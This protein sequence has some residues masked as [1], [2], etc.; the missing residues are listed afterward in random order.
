MAKISV[1]GPLAEISASCEGFG[2]V[3]TKQLADRLIDLVSA[4]LLSFS[5]LAVEIDA[6]NQAFLAELNATKFYAITPAMA[7]LVE[8]PQERFSDDVLR[9]FPEAASDIDEAGRCY[10]FGRHTAC[11]FHLMRVL[12]VP[13]QH[14]AKTLLPNDRKPNWAPII[15]KID[16]ELKLPYKQRSIIGPESFW[17]DVSARM[18]AVKIAWRNRVMHVDSIVTAE[19]AS[20]IFDATCGLMNFLS[21]HAEHFLHVDQPPS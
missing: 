10:A 2:G 16:T 7:K 5:K 20:S 15:E 11:V 17:A 14:L 1:T 8:R 19:R 18:H 3:V 6:L 9:V 13:L 21:D 4:E 12:E